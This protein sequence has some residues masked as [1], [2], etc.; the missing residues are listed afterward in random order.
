MFAERLKTLRK[1]AGLTQIEVA[2]QFNISQPAYAQ[3]E[4]GKKRPSAETLEKFAK[5]FEV[6]TDYLLGNTNN[7]NVEEI[8]LSEVEIL[9]RR[10]KQKMTEEEQKEFEDDLKRIIAER[11]QMMRDL[12]D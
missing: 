8:D 11:N 3:W 2:N 10:T 5:F 12:Q 1:E 9:F 4:T 7:K 6:S